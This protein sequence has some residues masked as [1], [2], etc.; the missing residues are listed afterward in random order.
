M[1]VFVLVFCAL[2]AFSPMAKASGIIVT[3]PAALEKISELIGLSVEQIT[4]MLEKGEENKVT[5]LMV[6]ALKEKREIMK[7]YEDEKN[8]KKRRMMW[9][10]CCRKCNSGCN[11]DSALKG[12]FFKYFWYK[13]SAVVYEK[14]KFKK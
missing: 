6:N 10:S 13:T 12:D 4:T 5:Q 14:T 11:V 3:D 7:I 9:N 8:I 2:I 1:A